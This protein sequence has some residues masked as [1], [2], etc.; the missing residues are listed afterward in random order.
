MLFGTFGSFTCIQRSGRRREQPRNAGPV[1]R[2]VRAR[3]EVSGRADDVPVLEADDVRSRVELFLADDARTVQEQRSHR[4]AAAR[5]LFQLR[6]AN[7]RLQSAAD[8]SCGG[9]ADAQARLAID[10]GQVDDVARIDQVR[11]LDLPVC[12]PDFRPQPGLFQE[13][14][15]DAPERVALLHRVAVRMAV[16]QFDI[17]GVDRQGQQQDDKN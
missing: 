4:V 10:V 16:V 11:V 1:A 6:G 9:F 15:R 14:R 5:S 13:T 12:L 17:G 7:V 2:R 3:S 8:S